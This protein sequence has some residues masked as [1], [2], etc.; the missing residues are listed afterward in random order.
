MTLSSR[1]LTALCGALIA[2]L[3]LGA[4]GAPAETPAATPDYTAL[5]TQVAVKLAATLTAKAPPTATPTPTP[6]RPTSTPQPTATPTPTPAPTKP[7][8]GAELAYVRVLSDNST[9]I[10]LSD[11]SQQNEQLLTHFVEADNM[12]DVA[13]APDGSALVFVSAHDFI[14]SRNNERNVFTMRAD[15]TGLRM[16]TGHYQDP[17]SAAGPYVTLR[18]IVAGCEGAALVSAQGVPAPVTT[19]AAGAFELLCVPVGAGWARAICPGGAYVLRNADLACTGGDNGVDI[20]VGRAVGLDR[21]PLPRRAH[22]RRAHLL[23][24]A[25]RRGQP[26]A[27]DRPRPPGY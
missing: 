20:T 14:H 3:A 11:E 23:L 25:R 2:L 19:D 12:C 18:G 16:V 10:V 13:W 26:A 5:E 27:L 7:A 21:R 8:I 17:Q 6:P 15:G 4:C 1:P 24:G 22:H 9:N